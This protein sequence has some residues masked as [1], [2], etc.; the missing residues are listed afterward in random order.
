[1]YLESRTF[2]TIK[3]TFVGESKVKSE[4]TKKWWVLFQ[5]EMLSSE[6]NSPLK[7][8]KVPCGKFDMIL[9]HF[10][11]FSQRTKSSLLMVK[12]NFKNYFVYKH[13]K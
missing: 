9:M 6:G 10:I 5:D 3:G 12:I 1:M 11:I 2:E 13:R 8:L 7:I 4:P